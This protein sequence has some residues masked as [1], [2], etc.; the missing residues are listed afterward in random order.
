MQAVDPI[1]LLL[2]LVFHGP[3]FR[4]NFRSQP[5]RW[6][7]PWVGDGLAPEAIH[8]IEHYDAPGRAINASAFSDFSGYEAMEVV[9][10]SFGRHVQAGIS[11]DD[12]LKVPEMAIQLLDAFYRLEPPVKRRYLRACYWFNLGRF[13]FDYSHSASFFA[14][15]VAIESMLDDQPPHECG[16]CGLPHHASITAAFREFLTLY[17][18]NPPERESFY[19]ARSKIAHGSKLF[20]ADALEEFGGFF[21]IRLNERAQHDQLSATC[22]TALLNWLT[23]QER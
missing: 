6:V 2:P 11:V 8:G 13:L 15:V 18:P 14:Y 12:C 17:I 23:S 1:R 19:A 22:R 21:P 9:E 16:E 4:P 3:I 20:E 5:N 10:D 7:M